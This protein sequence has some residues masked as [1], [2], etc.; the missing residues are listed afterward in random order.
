MYIAVPYCQEGDLRK[1]IN[2]K[3]MVFTE[4]EAI[5]IMK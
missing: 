4:K 1:E 3:N 2:K 5:N